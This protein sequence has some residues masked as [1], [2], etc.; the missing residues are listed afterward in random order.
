MEIVKENG[1]IWGVEK[2]E[3]YGI[4]HYSRILIGEYED[5]SGED[6]SS[7]HEPSCEEKKTK[8]TNRNKNPVK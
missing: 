3:M 1:K 8:K 7:K 4:T 6:N 5:N 2:M